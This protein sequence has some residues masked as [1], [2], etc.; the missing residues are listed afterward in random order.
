M[1]EIKIEAENVLSALSRLEQAA[2]NASPV[3]AAI[4]GVM[5]DAVE[6]NFAQEGRPKWAGLSPRTLKRRAGGKILQDR[7]RLAASI[8]ER[9]DANSAAVGTNVVYA[10]IH[11]FGGQIDKAAQS[12]LVRHRTDAKGNLLRSE[13]LGGKGL[14]F[15]K[16]SHKRVKS[17]WF[18]QAAHKIDMPARPFLALT[19]E[20]EE[21]IVAK[22]NDYL[23]S[24]IG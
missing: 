17:R 18:E 10:A 24:V 4:A 20:D 21:R 15:A 8:V 13:H 12:R 6:E 7:G 2:T 23:K 9:H 22:V 16:N 11:Q 3:M 5:H 19:G 1:I 14:I